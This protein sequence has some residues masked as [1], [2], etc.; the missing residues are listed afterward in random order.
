MCLGTNGR[1]DHKWGSANTWPINN[2]LLA[3]ESLVSTS[4]GAYRVAQDTKL[5]TE[6]TKKNR[7]MIFNFFFF[8]KKNKTESLL[9][10]YIIRLSTFSISSD[11]SFLQFLICL[12]FGVVNK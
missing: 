2:L 5:K 4:C 10:Y 1:W 7:K 6:T 8:K 9:H 12:D 3:E 11:F